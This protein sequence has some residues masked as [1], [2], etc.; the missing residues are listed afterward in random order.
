MKDYVVLYRI[1][2]YSALDI[3]FAFVCGAEDTVH[4]EEQMLN[5]CEDAEIVWIYQGND[6]DLALDDYWDF[7]YG[8]AE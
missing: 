5:F 1:D 6:V 2:G 3:P 7:E 4:V 8:V